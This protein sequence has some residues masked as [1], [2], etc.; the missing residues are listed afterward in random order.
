M[1]GW[2]GR[3]LTE[4]KHRQRKTHGVV[5]IRSQEEHAV[6]E[7]APDEDVG[8]NAR[9]Q[10]IRMK[11]H[12][13]NPIQ[14]D[15]IPRQ[16]P[17]NSA[18]V[19]QPRRGA[20]AKVQRGQIEEIQHKQE[21]CKPKVTAHPQV[22]ETEEQEVIGDEVASDV[23]GRANV[24]RVAHVQRVGVE[25][26]QDE[27]HDPVDGREDAGLCK[28][29]TVVVC[30]EAVVA[31]V[32][33]GRFEGVEDGGY[34]EKQPG[35]RGCD[36]VEEDGLRGVLVSL[37]EGVQVAAVAGGGGFGHDAGSVGCSS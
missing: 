6:T 32:S 10:V 19:N 26:L 15:E 16:R 7:P 37:G 35:K 2:G 8:Y 20:M 30:P 22:H 31:D 14:R 29:R 23:G 33:A 36:L 27:E 17:T 34:E 5:L 11:R 4:R 3:R 12:S 13:T 28:R 25:E 24:H 1:L 18:D 9:S 21:L